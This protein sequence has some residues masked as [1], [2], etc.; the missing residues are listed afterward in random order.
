MQRKMKWF[1]GVTLAGGLVV[2]S[3]VATGVSAQTTPP[4]PGF[5]PGYGMMGGGFGPRSQTATPQG[6]GAGFGMTGGGFGPNVGHA[7]IANAL[8]ITSQELWDA[9]VAGKSVADLAKDENVDLSTVVDAV[10][11]AHTAQLDAA[12][13]AGTLTQA[14]ADA[15]Q[16]LMKSRIQSQFQANT[17][18]GAWGPGMMGGRGM[19]DG[20]GFGP[21]GRDTR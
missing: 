7:A 18:G 16:A 6:P 9:R 21:R 20:R 3:I 15:M 2:G 10:L 4:G 17:A 8:G 19:A 13:K 5:G 11:A 1:A 12:V 14:Q